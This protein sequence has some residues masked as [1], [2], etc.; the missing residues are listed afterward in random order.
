M[1]LSTF[2]VMLLAFTGAAVTVIWVTVLAI[3]QVKRHAVRSAPGHLSAE[4]LD[5]L[6]A[7]LAELEQRDVRVGEIEERLD[8]MERVLGQARGATPL[9]DPSEK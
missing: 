1:N 8:F 7:R 9:R 6:R 2:L 4:E 3:G 5:D